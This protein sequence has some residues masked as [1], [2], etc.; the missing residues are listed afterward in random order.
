M[1][2]GEGA[3]N[4]LKENESQIELSVMYGKG[5]TQG[6]KELCAPERSAGASENIPAGF[7]DVD[8]GWALVGVGS[9]GSMYLSASG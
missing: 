7:C 2:I 3:S 8:A 9:F 6:S 4:A 5:F 1:L